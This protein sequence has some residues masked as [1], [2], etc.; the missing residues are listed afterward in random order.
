MDSTWMKV[1]VK[2]HFQGKKKKF[3]SIKSTS[4]CKIYLQYINMYVDTVQYGWYWS[5]FWLT[6]L[7]FV[8][9]YLISNKINNIKYS[10]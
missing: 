3:L 7:L 1:N 6:V 4:K 9:L 10:V 2:S 5:F 8:S